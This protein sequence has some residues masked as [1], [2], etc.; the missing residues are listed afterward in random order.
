MTISLGWVSTGVRLPEEGRYV[1]VHLTKTNW[2]SNND[3]EGVY[4]KVAQ[5]VTGISMAEREAMKD[6]S[7]PD[8]DSAGYI[9]EGT[10]WK[11]SISKRS[12]TYKAEDEDGNNHRPYNWCTFGPSNYFGQEVDKWMEIPR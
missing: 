8:P 2:H 12:S 9:A 7:I 1:L 6:G 4:F 3:P 5:M 10:T 11:E